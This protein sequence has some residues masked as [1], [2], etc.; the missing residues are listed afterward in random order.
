L[1]KHG[2]F[3]QISSIKV[4]MQ[5]LYDHDRFEDVYDIMAISVR[6]QLKGLKYNSDALMIAVATCLKQVRCNVFVSM[7]FI[8]ASVVL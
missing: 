8:L 1:D 6:K 7:S 2:F 4:L 3:D 5:L